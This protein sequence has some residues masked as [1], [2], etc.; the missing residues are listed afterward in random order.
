MDYFQTLN[1]VQKQIDNM[2]APQKELLAKQEAFRSKIQFM[3]QTNSAFLKMREIQQSVE[4]LKSTMEKPQL[5]VNYIESYNSVREFANYYKD[6]SQYE[7]TIHI[8]NIEP[9]ITLLNE[10]QKEQVKEI[11]REVLQEAS[12][13]EKAKDSK[14]SIFSNSMTLFVSIPGLEEAIMYYYVFIKDLYQHFF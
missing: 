13:G 9:E 11:F 14:L 3:N 1:T 5:L 6:E 7:S 4:L 8:P 12:K 10:E 2:L